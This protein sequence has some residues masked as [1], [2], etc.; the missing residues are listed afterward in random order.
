MKTTHLQIT[1]NAELFYTREQQCV[2]YMAFGEGGV[3]LLQSYTSE[4]IESLDDDTLSSIMLG[5]DCI[6]AVFVKAIENKNR[7]I[8]QIAL[9]LA[10]MVGEPVKINEILRM[11]PTGNTVKLDQE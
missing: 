1:T 3:P 11:N 10:E 9:E 8:G 5:L 7:K 6:H 4:E 2:N